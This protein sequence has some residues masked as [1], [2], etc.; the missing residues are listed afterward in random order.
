MG[1]C[2]SGV[3]VTLLLTPKPPRRSSGVRYNSNNPFN[4]H[5]HFFLKNNV[6]NAPVPHVDH[7]TPAVPGG[8]QVES[9]FQH[10][11]GCPHQ[12]YNC[13]SPD[14]AFYNNTVYILTRTSN[15]PRF[16][17]GCRASVAEQTHRNIVHVV[18]TDD[19][20]SLAYINQSEVVV[21]LILSNN[22]AFDAHEP[23]E[24]CGASPSKGCGNA[25]PLARMKARLHF[26]ACYCNT[27]YPMNA[28]FDHLHPLV[29]DGWVMYLDDD[30][31]LLDKHSVDRA[32]AHAT[33][34]N[35]MLIWR[36]KLGRITPS[37][38][39]FGRIVMGDI[40]ASNFMFHSTWL[41]LTQWH[42]PLRCGDYRTAV[43][44]ASALRTVWIN[45]TLV[46]AHPLRA[47]LGGL[48]LRHDAPHDVPV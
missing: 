8:P 20:N 41:N 1:E 18:A 28:Y 3:V 30:N 2:G 27:S 38:Q 6:R 17:Q 12:H 33:S 44:L 43:S 34:R 47:R 35:D 32:L 19:T 24:K 40:D 22:V 46:V 21:K 23:C 9:T 16:F 15:R 29:N 7:K 39:G 36:S 37:D 25:P 26:L 48:G 11:R 13:A 31:M 45:D 14:A 5:F 4:R 42:V 10:A